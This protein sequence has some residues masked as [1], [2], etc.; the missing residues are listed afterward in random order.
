M[1]QLGV[2]DTKQFGAR[3]VY[4]YD[5]V[6]EEFYYASYNEDNSIRCN[7]DLT[8]LDIH[9]TKWCRGSVIRIVLDCDKGKIRFYLNGIQVRKAV[10]IEKGPTYYPIVVFSGDCKYRIIK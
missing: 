5:H 6:D 9:Q 1:N 4:G 2:C 8:Q 10:S 7:K 3:A